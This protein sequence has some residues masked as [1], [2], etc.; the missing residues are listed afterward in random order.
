MVPFAKELAEYAEHLR[1]HRDSPLQPDERRVDAAAQDVPVVLR[2]LQER[3]PYLPVGNPDPNGKIIGVHNLAAMLAMRGH[4]PIIASW[5]IYRLIERGFL[6]AEIAIIYVPEAPG[7]ARFEKKARR[8]CRQAKTPGGP[9]DVID[10]T[11]TVRE[12]EVTAFQIPISMK[13]GPL[14]VTREATRDRQS[15]F[16]EPGKSYTSYSYLV[17]WPTEE[18]WDW[19]K[20][21][22]RAKLSLSAEP[23]QTA[24]P[25]PPDGFRFDGVEGHVRRPKVWKLINYLWHA[26]GQTAV[27]ADL[28]EPVWGDR[29][30][31]V[32]ENN[33]SS[34][35]RDANHFFEENG[36]PFKVQL[37]NGYASLTGFRS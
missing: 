28:A 10:R 36:W 33:V 18:L 32:G 19:W 3:D 1:I 15:D 17:F 2:N 4:D 24:G 31:F 13:P 30:E 7:S 5:A 9:G 25:F 8:A 11:G 20:H 12:N 23:D 37:K 26:R 29:E 14:Y 35:R 22:P 27:F 34:L 6:G 21:S 16:Q